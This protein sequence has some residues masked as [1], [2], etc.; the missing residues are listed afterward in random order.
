MAALGGPFALWKVDRLDNQDGWQ[1]GIS[2]LARNAPAE[3]RHGSDGASPFHKGLV[4]VLE[5]GARLI[6]VAAVVS[7]SLRLEE[8]LNLLI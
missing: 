6:F 8:R 5:R 1:R 7:T 4:F 3:L 2:F